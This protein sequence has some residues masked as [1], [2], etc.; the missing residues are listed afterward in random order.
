MK[1]VLKTTCL[2]RPLALRPLLS[3]RRGWSYKT[4]FTAVTSS[5]IECYKNLR[6]RHAIF[7]CLLLCWFLSLIRIKYPS[8]CTTHQRLA[9]NFAEAQTLI[10]VKY[11]WTHYATYMYV[12][13]CSIVHVIMVINAC[14]VTL[15]H[16]KYDRLKT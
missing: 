6:Q 13:V 2:E 15:C 16:Q 7:V 12:H 3:D 14:I 5:Y 11:S 10:A 4:G 8:F 9:V 1:T